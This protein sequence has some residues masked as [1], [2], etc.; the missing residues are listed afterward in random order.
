MKFETVFTKPFHFEGNMVFDAKNRIC[1]NVYT[2]E[3]V[4]KELLNKLNG[5]HNKKPQFA[6]TLS[7]DK[8]NILYQGK[9]VFLVR[10]WGRLTGLGG[11]NLSSAKAYELQKDFADWI[12]KILNK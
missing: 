6:F 7:R 3:H 1:L 5:L 10:A 12:I 8:A 4:T 9:K 2:N 11:L